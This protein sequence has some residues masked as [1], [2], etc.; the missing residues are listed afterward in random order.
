MP[1][2]V[3][4]PV[5]DTHPGKQ[6]HKW[7]CQTDACRLA[8]VCGVGL[9]I[10]LASL[11]PGE[12]CALWL[13]KVVFPLCS[14]A[15]RTFYGCF[16]EEKYVNILHHLPLFMVPGILPLGLNWV[17]M[18]L[19]LCCCSTHHNFQMFPSKWISGGHCS[20]RLLFCLFL[21]TFSFLFHSLN[22]CSDLT[23]EKLKRHL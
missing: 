18:L 1:C 12:F 11:F 19:V 17:K 16:S 4:L 8:E 6:E 20:F 13:Q 7:R 9:D 3:P 21:E 15:E 10:H 2:V 5:N 22:C 23:S 14:A